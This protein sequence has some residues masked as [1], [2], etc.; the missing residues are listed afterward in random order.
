M[1]KGRL[2][3]NG[4][5]GGRPESPKGQLST[6]EFHA[7]VIGPHHTAIDGRVKWRPLLTRATC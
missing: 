5:K 3:A 6:E 1:G 7:A 4:K 2:P